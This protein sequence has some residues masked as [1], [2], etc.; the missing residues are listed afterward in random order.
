MRHATTTKLQRKAT[1]Y[2]NYAKTFRLLRLLTR[3]R[4][5][6]VVYRRLTVLLCLCRSDIFIIVVQD[7]ACTWHTHTHTSL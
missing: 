5:T 6:A 7:S 3:C 2:L 4:L 1:I